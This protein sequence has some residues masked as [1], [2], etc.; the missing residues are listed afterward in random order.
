[1]P[2]VST[3]AAIV[4]QHEP[5]GGLETEVAALLEAAGAHTTQAIMEAEEQLALKVRGAT[6]HFGTKMTHGIQEFKVYCG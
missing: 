2:R 3:T 4:A 5:E 6:P 1:M